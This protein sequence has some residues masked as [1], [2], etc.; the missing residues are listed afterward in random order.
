V[1]S[2]YR[3]LAIL[4]VQSV[5]KDQN[6]RIISYVLAGTPLTFESKMATASI[7]LFHIQIPCTQGVYTGL[8]DSQNK[9]QVFL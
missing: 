3:V 6:I 8:Y 9:N 5:W 1:L 4:A 7:P 2:V